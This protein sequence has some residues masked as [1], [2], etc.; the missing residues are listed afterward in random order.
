MADIISGKE[1]FSGNKKA[2]I[3]KQNASKT[4]Q[5]SA[6]YDYEDDDARVKDNHKEAVIKHKLRVAAIVIIIAII[7]AVVAAIAVKN[8]DNTQYTTYTVE[9]SLNREDLESSAYLAY[10]SG[11]IRY[12]NDGISY[13]NVDGVA[14]WNQ[15]FS[16]Q[17]PSVK[18]CEDIIAVADIDGT[19]VYT[20]DS[21][22]LISSIDTSLTVL[23]IAVAK[24]G[25]V[26]AVLEDN[27]ANYI[28]MYDKS[29]DKVYS[30]KT[31]LAG[32]GYPLD[33]DVS[34][35]A[36]K[37]MASFV[38]VSGES[39]KTH[40]VFY[41]FSEVGQNVTERVVGGFDHY[42][43]VIV[44]DVEFIT[45]DI[46]VAVGE[47]VV[48]IYKI[49][50]YP[51]LEKEITI[52]E[53]I[54]KV[55][56]SEKYIGVMVDNSSVGDLYKLMV[57]NTSGNQVC[58]MTFNTKY[59]NLSFDDNSIVLNNSSSILLS[60]MTGKQL[61]NISID[62]SIDYVITTGKR[63]NYVVVNSKYIQNIKLKP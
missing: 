6:Y 36:T 22:G 57:Y 15:T 21:Q 61:A 3:K 40:V 46:A 51:S 56:F 49:K 62:M 10:Q 24:N 31:T 19:K 2:P 11:Y 33:I 54:E 44:G 47:N 43:D 9:N 23:Q 48:S 14:Q 5:V 8:I 12:S 1:R 41:N 20:F 13:Y 37:L 50:E 52:N 32:D 42:G 55:F 39:I 4:K 27:N 28:N 25:M 58:E 35:D 53:E 16:M 38:Y 60:N 63:A 29:G 34:S 45:N 7:I 18:I 17:K 59:D 26:A 30:V